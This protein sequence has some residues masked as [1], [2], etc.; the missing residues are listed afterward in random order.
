MAADFFSCVWCVSWLD[1]GAVARPAVAA[2]R[3]I[4]AGDFWVMN[5]GLPNKP[6]RP[7]RQTLGWRAPDGEAGVRGL[8]AAAG[9]PARSPAP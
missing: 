4:F 6:D 3:E 2:S 1:S 8:T 9:H 7:N 5:L